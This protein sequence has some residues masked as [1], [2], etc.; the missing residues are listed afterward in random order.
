MTLNRKERKRSYFSQRLGVRY[1]NMCQGE[2]VGRKRITVGLD[3][4][5]SRNGR[6]RSRI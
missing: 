4:K 3:L 2:E 6:N 1:S 5:K